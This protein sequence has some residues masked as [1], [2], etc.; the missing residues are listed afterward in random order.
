[1]NKPTAATR[2]KKKLCNPPVLLYVEM[3]EEAIRDGILSDHDVRDLID[4]DE[5]FVKRYKAILD[6]A[7]ER[8]A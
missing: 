5:E 3:A 2:S 1:M 8:L 6:G 4:Y 7:I